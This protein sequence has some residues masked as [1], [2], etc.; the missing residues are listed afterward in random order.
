MNDH[1]A[2]NSSKS[3]VIPT[4]LITDGMAMKFLPHADYLFIKNE[5]LKDF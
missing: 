1:I 3:L 4:A 2:K 5:P